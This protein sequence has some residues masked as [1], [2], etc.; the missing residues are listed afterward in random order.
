VTTPIA[1]HV[2]DILVEWYSNVSRWQPPGQTSNGTCSLCV[3]SPFS[4]QL[5]LA[6]WPHDVTHALVVRLTDAV[7]GMRELE[8]IQRALDGHRH[9]VLDVL[10]QCVRERF[11]RYLRGQA[12]IAVNEFEKTGE[13]NRS[14][15][16]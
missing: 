9:D 11:T 5:N 1:K 6:T 10:E 14:S 7:E 4:S 12:Q 3:S 15:L 16:E 13:W 2:D 8:Q